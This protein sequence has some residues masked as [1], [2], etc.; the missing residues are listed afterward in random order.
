MK[1]TEE[2][3]REIL[4]GSIELGKNRFTQSE[5]ACNLNASLSVVNLAL[6]P[7]RRMHAIDNHKMG[8]Y[9]VDKRK[10]LFYWASIRIV[11]KD[12][13][14]QTRVEKPVREIERSMPHNVIFG[15]Y[16]AY[17]FMFDDVPADYSEVY[18]YSDN[19]ENIK[20]RFPETI[21]P[22]NL[23]VLKRDS[24]LKK[25]TRAQIFVDLW[26]TKEWYARDFLDAIEVKINGFLE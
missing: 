8:F 18:A 19:L 21:G 15:A 26:N 23:F 22:P 11:D 16:S 12:I 24:N 17:K 13:I 25:M 1:R 3:Y 10:I 14:Y 7:L 5:L 9:V 4:F 2:V 20:K 6:K